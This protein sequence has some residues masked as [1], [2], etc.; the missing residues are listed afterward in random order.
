M[1]ATTNHR[2]E[3][4]GSVSDEAPPMLKSGS[5]RERKRDKH[6]LDAKM[7]KDEC[8][9][10]GELLDPRVLR[11]LWG[12]SGVSPPQVLD[13]ELKYR[14]T[15]EVGTRAVIFACEEKR[16][17]RNVM[18]FLLINLPRLA[19]DLQLPSPEQ[20]K[21]KGLLGGGRERRKKRHH[22]EKASETVRATAPEDPV[23]G[24][25]G[26]TKEIPEQR[27]TDTPYTLLD[28]ST[29]SSV[30][31]PSGSASLDFIR[32][33]VPDQDFDLV[34]SVPDLAVL[35]A[36]LV[37]TGEATTRLSQARDEIVRTKCSMDGMFGRHNDLLKQL[38]EMR[39]QEDRE[40]ESLRLELDV[41]RA[42]A[43][44]SKALA[45]SL[46]PKTFVAACIFL[47]GLG[48]LLFVLGSGFGAFLLILY[49]VLTSPV[50]Y[51]FY[52]S[53][54]GEPEFIRLLHEFLQVILKLSNSNKG[55]HFTNITLGWYTSCT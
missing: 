36:A 41:A 48:G 43:Q 44:S 52:N 30:A 22:E 31:K 2:S 4:V 35:E 47:K 11:W 13:E 28:A 17:L 32:R 12:A 55:L 37:W 15:T 39:A 14:I 25:V 16:G 49:L 45:Q 23:I 1:S 46:E 50:L 9:A 21:E 5:V 27:Y 53:D 3:D 54:V 40:K 33:L 6:M 29:L 24:T 38:E 26:A 42:N 18:P 19:K 51:D 8:V 10:S 20:R 34:K 7:C